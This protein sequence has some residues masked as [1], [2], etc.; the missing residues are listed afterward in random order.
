LFIEPILASHAHGEFEVFC[1]SNLSRPD[2]VTQ[3]LGSYADHWREVHALGDEA[4]ADLIREDAIDILV[5]LSGHTANNRLPVFGRK[6]APVQVTYLGYPGTTGLSAIDYR[7]TDAIV[8][9]EGGDERWYSE[10]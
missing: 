6:P 2:A 3:R 10:R 8:D 4:M 9:P 1:Y 7:L 5:D